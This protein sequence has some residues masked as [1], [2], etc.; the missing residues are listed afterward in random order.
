MPPCVAVTTNFRNAPGSVWLPETIPGTLAGD[1]VA[2]LSTWAVMNVAESLNS[3]G[4]ASEGRHLYPLTMMVCVVDAM[5]RVCTRTIN[6]TRLNMLVLT[7]G[8]MMT[9][10]DAVDVRYENSKR[11]LLRIARP[12]LRWIY[13]K[14]AL[15][16]PT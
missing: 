9:S 15:D 8:W 6:C 11:V 5:F 4:S 7:A 1:G 16:N 2:E 13:R 14:A 12:A 10:C 3:R